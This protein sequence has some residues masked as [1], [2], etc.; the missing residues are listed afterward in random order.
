MAQGSLLSKR[1]NGDVTVSPFPRNRRLRFC[2]RSTL[3]SIDARYIRQH[4]SVSL[5][6]LALIL[7]SGYED[8]FLID[9]ILQDVRELFALCVSLDMSNEALLHFMR[10]CKQHGIT[11]KGISKQDGWVDRVFPAISWSTR[12]CLERYRYTFRAP[13]LSQSR[14]FQRILLSDDVALPI[15]KLDNS[16][17]SLGGFSSVYK[18]VIHGWYLDNS[19]PLYQ[20]LKL[21]QSHSIIFLCK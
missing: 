17:P 5:G 3:N 4:F 18:V 9:Y 19:D 8:K 12:D 16:P 11:D 7:P 2:P 10:S 21:Q 15:V 1:I 20:V 14:K 13:V 6:S